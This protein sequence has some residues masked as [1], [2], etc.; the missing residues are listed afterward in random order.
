MDNGDIPIT[1]FQSKVFDTLNHSLILLYKLKY[2][3][4]KDCAIN[5]LNS[6]YL[7][8]RQQFVQ[9][10]IKCSFLL[11]KTGVLQGSILGPR[12]FIMMIPK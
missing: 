6:N 10:N 1:I 11:V 8:D 12:L 4:I 3:V 2:Y 5:F 7:S 9:I